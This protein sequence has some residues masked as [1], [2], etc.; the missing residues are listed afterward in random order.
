M[1]TEI[2]RKFLVTSE[3]W[4]DGSAGTA[5][6]QGY[7]NRE[8]D[9]TVRIRIAGDAAFITIKGRREGIARDEFEYPIPVADAEGLLAMCLPSPVIKT[10]YLVHHEGHCWEVDEFHGDNEG[11]IVAEIELSSVDE[12]FSRPPWL[13]EEVSLDSRYFNSRLAQFPYKAWPQPPG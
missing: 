4:R 9:R 8:P 3:A 5:L 13:G 11:L 7:L 1:G 10:R 12:P 2:E 6:K